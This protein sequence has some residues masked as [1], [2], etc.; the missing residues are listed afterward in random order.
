MERQNSPRLSY[1]NDL[2]VLNKNVNGKKEDLEVLSIQCAN[3]FE[4]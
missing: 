4:N 1:A 3:W 2:N